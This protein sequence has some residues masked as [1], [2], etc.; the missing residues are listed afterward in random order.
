M[1]EAR[2]GVVAINHDVRA[3]IERALHNAR[4][5]AYPLGEYVG[6]E[7]FM[8]ASEI[9]RLAERAGIGP[10]T[11][12]LDLCCG[13][14]GPGLLIARQ[15]G[16]PYHGVDVS[17]SAIEIARDRAHD[18]NC[19][20]DVVAIPPLP[21]GPYDVV[22]L[23]E[24]MLAFADKHDLLRHVSAALS[25]GGRFAFTIEVGEP[26]T[27]RE[28]Q[29][30]PESGTVW[31]TPLTRLHSYLDAA[32]LRVTLQVDC[33][34]THQAVAQRLYDELSVNAD[35]IGTQLGNETVD[36]LLTAHRLWSEW[37]RSGRVRKFAVVAERT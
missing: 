33:S 29:S 5:A 4:V 23:F 7:S 28:Q 25:P 12:V 9:V 36:S 37:L 22:L 1:S 11:S 16:C 18:L 17:A 35:D 26:L 32:G 2:A 3:A 21:S 6:Q 8:R 15:F 31:L 13:V 24:T 34:H 10:D 14:A 30:M 27:R 20:F 19:R